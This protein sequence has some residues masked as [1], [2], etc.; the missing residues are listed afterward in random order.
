[1]TLSSH[2]FC[3]QSRALAGGLTITLT[4]ALAFS[5]DAN[6]HRETFYQQHN[7]VSDGF[8]PADHVDNNLVNPWGISASP[9]TF[10]WVSDNG[11]GVTTLY[12]GAGNA[13]PLVVTIPPP[14][15][16]TDPSTPTGQV[17]NKFNATSPTDF[18]VT[19]GGASGPS[20]FIFA[21]EDGTISGWNPAVPP[22][23]LSKQAIRVVDNSAAGAV[24]KGLAI[25][26]NASGNF[27]YAANFSAGTI[28]VF[29]GSFTQVTLAGSFAD[30]GIPAGFAPFNVQNLGGNLYVTYAKRNDITGDDVAGPGNGFVDIFDTDGNLVRRVASGGHLNSPWGIALAPAKGFGRFSNDLLVGNFGDGQINAY[31]D[32]GGSFEFHG[33][34][35]SKGKPITIDGLWALQFGLGGANNGPTNVLFFTAGIDDERHGLFGSL[36]SCTVVSCP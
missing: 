2:H 5:A 19:S 21:T 3:R 16:S 11:T 10:F 17:F 36:T 29:N 20:L 26:S 28:D 35:R 30:P 1:M 23:P 15:G 9:A 24:Y 4:L 18:V 32:N 25:G 13:V 8:V 22:P 33:K 6:N 14:A 7:L 27:L 34:L 12:N 31:R